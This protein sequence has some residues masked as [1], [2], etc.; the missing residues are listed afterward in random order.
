MTCH[1][2]PIKTPRGGTTENEG[3]KIKRTF[4]R[5]IIKQQNENQIQQKSM[6]SKQTTTCEMQTE[7]TI[8]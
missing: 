7:K 1:L 6:K 4:I 2:L 8:L 5:T 3:K